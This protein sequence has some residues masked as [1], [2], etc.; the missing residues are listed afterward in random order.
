MSGY[1]TKKRTRA[2]FFIKVKSGANANTVAKAIY[3]KHGG[4]KGGNQFVLV[5]ADVVS[6]CTLGE[7]IASVDA[8]DDPQSSEKALKMA[9]RNIQ[10]VTGVDKTT[11]ALVSAHNPD[12][13][14]EA[15]GYVNEAE[16]VK[17]EKSKPKPV[18]DVKIAGRQSPYSPG[19]NKWG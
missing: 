6:G 14:H 19:S 10:R 5:R 3:E 9:E 17:G 8:I 11:K 16:K 1:S 4:T 12:P 2:W 13:P 7:I 18:K 15:Y